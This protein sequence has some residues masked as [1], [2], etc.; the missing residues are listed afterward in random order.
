MQVILTIFETPKPRI[1]A[2]AYEIAYIAR[3]VI[4]I[5][6]YFGGYA[7]DRALLTNRTFE[8]VSLLGP[9]L[10]CRLCLAGFGGAFVNISAAPLAARTAQDAMLIG[11]VSGKFLAW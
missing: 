11:L 8:R 3:V 10:L 6:N 5:R 1:A 2:I 9:C 4:V 7:H